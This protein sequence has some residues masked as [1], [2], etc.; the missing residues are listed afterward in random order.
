MLNAM[1]SAPAMHS[2]PNDFP[3][4]PERWRVD[5]GDAAIAKLEI[6]AHLRREREFE[7]AVMLTVRAAEG[8]DAWHRLQV[9]AD[10]ELQWSRR[11]ATQN[12]GAFDGLEFRFRRRVAV[13]RSLRL[14]AQSDG[15]A[16]QRL[17]LVIEAEEA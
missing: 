14:L 5:A 17:R 1:T 15:G 2:S 7:I 11:V 12:P 8:A 13:G 10:G 4:A 6:P 3:A 9:Y 16:V